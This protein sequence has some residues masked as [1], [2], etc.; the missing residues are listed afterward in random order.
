LFS[1]PSLVL[2]FNGLDVDAHTL[3][4]LFRG[5]N[6]T[7]VFQPIQGFAFGMPAQFKICA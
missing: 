7:S 5:S 2:I 6:E 4:S 1:V 3:V